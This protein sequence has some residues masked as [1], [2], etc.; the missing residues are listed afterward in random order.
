[1]LPGRGAS[2]EARIALSTSGLFPKGLEVVATDPAQPFAFAP[3]R[4][5]ESGDYKRASHQSCGM[6]VGMHLPALAL[7]V[8][9]SVS[10]SSFFNQTEPVSNP[11][12]PSWAQI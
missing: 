9:L 11:A 5:T 2:R 10:F 6:L 1:M 3:F 12:A 4:S 7:L 8:A